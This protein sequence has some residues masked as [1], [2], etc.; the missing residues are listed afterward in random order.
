MNGM[1]ENSFVLDTNAV[2]FLT[3]RGN[4]MP[5][6]LENKLNEAALYISVITEIESKL[7]VP[8][9]IIAA[10]SIIL[11]AVLLTNDDRL[12]GLSWPGFRTQN[13]F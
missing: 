6:D 7:K 4:A 11:D 3:T 1:I 2:I 9:C 12:L 5:S 8:D 13:I 10:T